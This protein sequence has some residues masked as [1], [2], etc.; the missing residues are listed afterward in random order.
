MYNACNVTDTVDL[1]ILRIDRH[2]FF[3]SRSSEASTVI[4]VKPVFEALSITW[5][6]C[7]A[8]L[9]PTFIFSRRID[10]GAILLHCIK[11]YRS[12]CLNPFHISG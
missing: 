5:G 4:D 2:V 8:L 9:P 11:L 6:D 10:D 1:V 12:H 3:T 7:E